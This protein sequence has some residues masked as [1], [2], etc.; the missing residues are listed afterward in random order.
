M[1]H[2]T[3]FQQRMTGKDKPGQLNKDGYAVVASM[4]SSTIARQQ[5][6]A[7]MQAEM[8]GDLKSLKLIQS[9]KEKERVKKENLV[10]KYMPF[11]DS[12]IAAAQTH[13][14]LGI[15]LVWLFDIKDIPNAVRVAL[16][17]IEHAIPMPE[18]F[19]R[20]LPTFLCDVILEWAEA[21]VE[22]GRSVEPYF[23]QVY[24][25]TKELDMPDQVRAKIFRLQGLIAYEKGDYA[26]AVVTLQEAADFGASVKTILGK[27]RKKLEA[28]ANTDGAQDPADAVEP[29]ADSAAEKE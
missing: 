16:F 1:G 24:E 21:E 17:C 15:L 11:A 8:D 25:L 10:P 20:D 2:M 27:A 28:Q 12:L 14:I 18:W 6:F 4:P 13:P 7:K 19:K 23:S 3:N 5:T 29:K 22:A 9:V 26:T